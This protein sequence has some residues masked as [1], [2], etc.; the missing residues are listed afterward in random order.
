MYFRNV[1][2]KGRRMRNILA[3]ISLILLV[4]QLPCLASAA[5]KYK[6]TGPF[7]LETVTEK[8]SFVPLHG[9]MAFDQGKLIYLACQIEERRAMVMLDLATMKTVTILAPEMPQLPPGSDGV[10]V[11]ETPL[12]YEP[13]HK[14]AGMVLRSG[15]RIRGDAKVMVWDP[16]TGEILRILTIVEGK[17]IYYNGVKFIGYSPERDEAFIEIAQ[18]KNGKEVTWVEGF[19]D[20]VRRIA[21]IT[22]HSRW[23]SKGPYYDNTHLRSFH[24]EYGEYENSGAMGHMVDLM[25]GEVKSYPMGAAEYGFEFDPDGNTAYAY[26]AKSG[27]L[28]KFDLD[29]GTVL[30]TARYGRLGHVL[31]FVAPGQLVLMLNSR[32]CFINPST[33][34]ERDGIS[35][36]EFHKVGSTHVEGSLILPNR[37]IARIFRDMYVL[38]L[39]GNNSGS[40]NPSPAPAAVAPEKDEKPVGKFFE[41]KDKRHYATVDK[42]PKTGGWILGYCDHRGRVMWAKKPCCNG[43]PGGIPPFVFSEDGSLVAMYGEGE[44]DCMRRGASSCFGVRLFDSNGNLKYFARG[45]SN[46]A[47]SPNG[48]YATWMN[49]REAYLLKTGSKK[50]KQ[51]PKPEAK[52][53]PVAVSDKGKVSY[54]AGST[55]K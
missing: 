32:L 52:K 13:A 28:K 2:I 20:K 49:G 54:S 39:F 24:M 40:V 45:A 42:N 41:A 38:D 50:P 48:L 10:F 36:N 12:W 18:S 43:M 16:N 21:D 46:V 6:S 55:D 8:P 22:V 1:R 29:T 25:T 15:N 4:N 7:S 27:E 31:G 51:L 34:R 23:G 5:P 9:L 33:L 44:G 35:T 3:G 26:A 14:T 19:T 30:K 37:I 53:I 17:D 11:P 47:L